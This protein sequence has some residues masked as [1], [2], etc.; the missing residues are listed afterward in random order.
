MST[1]MR[2][3]LSVTLA[4][5][6]SAGGARADCSGGTCIPGGGPADSDCHAEFFGTGLLLNTPFF[7]PAKP[8]AKKE[9]RCFDGD[10]GCDGD[11]EVN[12][13]C[14]FNVALCL[15]NQDPNL[16]ACTPAS[17]E[18]MK[19]KTGKQAQGGPELAAAADLLLPTAGPV[20]TA[21]YEI[22]VPIKQSKSGRR[23]PGKTIVRAKAMTSARSDADKLKLQCLPREWPSHGY[24][25]RNRR[26]TP[27]E[28]QIGPAT[29][30]SLQLVW[31]VPLDRAVTS[32]PA[33]G[34]KLV[35]ATS[36]NGIV[37][38]LK[39]KN[40]DEKWTYDSG[41]NTLGVQSSPTLTADGRLL[42]G[43]SLGIVHCL[44]ARKGTLLWRTDVA[45]PGRPDHF[46]SSPAV[47]NNR[48]IYGLASHS[49]IPCTQGRLVALDLDTGAVLWNLKTAPDKV[50]DTDTAVA[51]DTD[52]DCPE[53]GTCIEGK[54]AGITATV[55][56][57]ETG[58]NV[59]MNTVGC[60]TFPS[61]GD[62]DSMF[63][64]DAATGDVVWKNRVDAPE[65]FGSCQDEPAV[66]CGTDSFCTTGSCARKAFYHDFGFL[67]GPMIIDADDGTGGSRRLIVSGSKNGSLY[68][69]DPDDG[70]IVW[71]NAV[72]PTPISPGFAA[73]GLFNGAIGFADGRIHAV[74]NRMA[75]GRVDET[76]QAY[77][78]VDGSLVWSDDVQ[79]SWGDVTI[80]NGV[81]FGGT[82]EGGNELYAYDAAT[83]TRLATFLMP[84]G[85][86]VPG[87]AAVVDGWLY[88][89][90]GVFGPGGVRA[91]ALP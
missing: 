76:F 50:C 41:A 23:K 56:I 15:S 73:F 80:A 63:R 51:C 6:L 4:A 83:G 7:D 66:D 52:A 44:D 48:V 37:Y 19:V 20:C 72:L 32:T 13:T 53:D 9:L 75:P 5:V 17:V 78:A 40:G 77:S 85:A 42:I 67:N 57:D 79:P 34:N 64:V 8:K 60:F 90:Y 38:A 91:Y 88:T 24:D 47:A 54:G 26:A 14:A 84:E 89:G 36:A 28:T 16:P 10:A 25:Q 22:V 49:D 61:I 1:P 21:Q 27:Q 39:Q 29:V 70:D 43:D 71:R 55:A 59:Y 33:V 65:Q 35:Y 62:S 30:A 87:G 46:W 18:Q 81:V 31:D 11:G 68:A 12:G 45:A 2:L 69:F 3:L 82:Q 74:L 86:N 58:E